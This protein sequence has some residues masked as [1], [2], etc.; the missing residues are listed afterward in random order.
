MSKLDPT[1]GSDRPP[2]SSALILTLLCAVIIG[3]ATGAIFLVR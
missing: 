1:N 2:A 3:L